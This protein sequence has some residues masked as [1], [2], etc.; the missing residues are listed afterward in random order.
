MNISFQTYDF[1]SS[2]EYKGWY[3]EEC[4]A[5]LPI[6]FHCMGKKYNGNRNCLINKILQNRQLNNEN[7]SAL[8]QMMTKRFI[9]AFLEGWISFKHDAFAQCLKGPSDL[10]LLII[11]K[12]KRVN[13]VRSLIKLF[14]LAY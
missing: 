11:E 5:S 8:E 3:S 13:T 10:R 7:P 2:V 14:N 4:W 6:D 9:L 1:L 12:H